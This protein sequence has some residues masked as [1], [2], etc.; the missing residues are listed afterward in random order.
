MTDGIVLYRSVVGR[1]GDHRAVLFGRTAAQRADQT[2]AASCGSAYF[3]VVGAVVEFGSRTERE[4]AN[5]SDVHTRTPVGCVGDATGLHIAVVDDGVV[6][7]FAADGRGLDASGDTGEHHQRGVG[8][9]AREDHRDIVSDV[10]DRRSFGVTRQCTGRY[11]VLTRTHEGNLIPCGAQFEVFDRSVLYRS[12]QAV[13]MGRLVLDVE[14]PSDSLDRETLAVEHAREGVCQRIVGGRSGGL[15]LSDRSPFGKFRQIDVV[16]QHHL[17]RSVLPTIRASAGVDGLGKGHEVCAR[18]DARF[19]RGVGNDRRLADAERYGDAV[20]AIRECDR[21]FAV[22]AAVVFIVVGYE[23]VGRRDR[24]RACLGGGFEP[25]LTLL[26]DRYLIVDVGRHP[27]VEFREFAFE[28]DL[29][30]RS[31]LRI[32][33]RRVDLGRSIGEE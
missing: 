9:V 29:R 3:A 31:E 8:I 32:P 11:D 21:A 7:R 4:G 20:G 15:A 14:G 12:E 22:S 6:F 24:L 30:S 27:D 1:V 28:S 25:R 18:C 17:S 5:A 33:R 10:D 13:E 23:R 2:A 19:G 26:C 16:E